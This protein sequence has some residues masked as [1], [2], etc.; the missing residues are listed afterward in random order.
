M[1][2]SHFNRRLPGREKEREGGAGPWNI[3]VIA[4][5]GMTPVARSVFVLQIFCPSI[6]VPLQ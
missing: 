5:L 6:A 1:I 2:R 4:A 3:L